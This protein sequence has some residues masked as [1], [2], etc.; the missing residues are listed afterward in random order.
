MSAQSSLPS[1]PTDWSKFRDEHPSIRGM[2]LTVGT[3]IQ[4]SG[5]CTD[6]TRRYDFQC[7]VASETNR[8]HWLPPLGFTWN[9]YSVGRDAIGGARKIID[10]LQLESQPLGELCLTAALR[11]VMTVQHDSSK[12][13]LGQTTVELYK[14][15]LPVVSEWSV[16]TKGDDILRVRIHMSSP[17]TD[18]NMGQGIEMSV[19]SANLKF[20]EESLLGASVQRLQPRVTELGQSTG[21][22]FTCTGV[23]IHPSS[24]ALWP[25]HGEDNVD[26]E[27][28][29]QTQRLL[30]NFI[31]QKPKGMEDQ[32]PDPSTLLDDEGSEVSGTS[33]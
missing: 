31:L 32:L 8:S 15:T 26:R 29:E 12:K 2:K 7:L 11:A 27:V 18:S 5:I 3:G 30:P 14:K 6:E 9:G 28:F 4:G 10:A 33:V 16:G 13:K 20:I 24:F 23:G 19:R 21:L 25:N 1:G 22:S 17:P